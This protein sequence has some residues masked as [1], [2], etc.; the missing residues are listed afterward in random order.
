[1]TAPDPT[2]PTPGREAR[3]HDLKTWPAPFREVRSGAKRFEIRK[4]DRDYRVGDTLRLREWSDVAC[5]YTG[6]EVSARVTYLLAGADAEQFGCAP[7]YC[8][9]GIRLSDEAA[10]LALRDA[11]IERLRREIEQT[12]DYLTDADGEPRELAQGDSADV[13]RELRAALAPV[14]E[15][16]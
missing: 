12:A 7:G 2:T 13:V 11:E 10:E 1:M 15:P 9:M 16:T 6:P 3:E 5:V 8:V 14:K 4:N